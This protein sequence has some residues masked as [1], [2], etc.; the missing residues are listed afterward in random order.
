M[1]VTTM[2][3]RLQ[4]ETLRSR[5]GVLAIID[6]LEKI[7]PLLK[8]AAAQEVSQGVAAADA[9]AKARAERR[10]ERER[11]DKEKAA[12]EAADADKVTAAEPA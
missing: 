7:A 10:A 8:E 2:A 6:E 3:C 1:P 9:K 11:A 4:K 12:A 5:A